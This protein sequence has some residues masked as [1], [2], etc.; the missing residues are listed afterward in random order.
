M[1]T[2]SKRDRERCSNTQVSP[3][4]Q[5]EELQRLMKRIFGQELTAQAIQRLMAERIQQI[6]TKSQK[7]IMK[8]SSG[9]DRVTPE[10]AKQI[11]YDYGVLVHRVHDTST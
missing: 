2:R 11:A 6:I 10:R 8:E 4:P 5:V 3:R 9:T 1:H 7:Q